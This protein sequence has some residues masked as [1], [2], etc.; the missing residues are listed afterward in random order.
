VL[1]GWLVFS[2]IQAQEFSF[3][4]SVRV[5]GSRSYTYEALEALKKREES[6]RTVVNFTDD[7]YARRVQ[8]M[9]NEIPMK[10]TEL[11]KSYVKAYVTRRRANTEEMVSRSMVYFPIF[12]ETFQR[13]GVP[14][15]LK[16]LAIVESSLNPRAVSPA[17]ATGIWQFMAPTAKQYKLKITRTIDERRDPYASTH[18]AAQ[19][20]A[21]LYERYGDWN[22][23]I[24]SYNC[25]PGRVNKALEQA[26][27]S[28]YWAAA[29]YMPTETRNYVP[30]FI[31]VAYAMNYYHEHNIYPE[32]PE[33][34]LQITDK[35]YVHDNVSFSQ[36][37]KITGV[38]E[39]AIRFL[40]PALNQNYI[41]ES[42][43][44]H[45][46]TLPLT[47][48]ASLRASVKTSY[49]DFAERGTTTYEE[50]Y[51]VTKPAPVDYEPPTPAPAPPPPVA[52]AESSNK[53]EVVHYVKRGENLGT[54]AEKYNCSVADLRKWN[55]MKGSLLQVGQKI[56][57]GEAKNPEPATPPVKVTTPKTKTAK[58]FDNASAKG[59][60]HTIQRGETLMGIATKNG[61][62][63]AEILKVNGLNANDKIQPGMELIIP[64]K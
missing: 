62:S 36:I 49:V 19:Y 32:H 37:S 21:D 4:S 45:I 38:T 25:G 60:T 14:S 1:G 15:E 26:G 35:V 5:G 39:E 24:A 9:S 7:E 23:A 16:Y 44:G 2:S 61:V 57:I 59:K 13:N 43:E 31:G 41:P 10:F 54:I 22:L 18:A 46:F 51:M 28:N 20:L 27:T 55:D 42:K 3:P 29:S 33:Y 11:V 40:N 58:A 53:K 34:D 52:K 17:G 56:V 8:A 64:T 63:L 47:V 50:A 30:A 12:E 48:M 6:P